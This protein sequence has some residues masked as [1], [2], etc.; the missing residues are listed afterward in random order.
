MTKHFQKVQFTNRNQCVYLYNVH[1]LTLYSISKLRSFLC[2]CIHVSLWLKISYMQL[3]N[4]I[5]LR[6][7]HQKKIS[8]NDF[9][10]NSNLQVIFCTNK[11]EN[12]CRILHT[13]YVFL[14][15]LCIFVECTLCLS[16][17]YS[18]HNFRVAVFS[19]GPKLLPKPQKE[20][21]FQRRDRSFSN[22][23]FGVR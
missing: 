8:L 18:H 21:E 1:T 4:L 11:L 14:Q 7:I 16:A 15:Q 10:N 22:K 2:V 3:K 9:A 6:A 19:Y 13:R 12:N 23:K 5:K 20:W 17:V